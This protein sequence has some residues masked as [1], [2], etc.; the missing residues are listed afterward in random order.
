[1]NR[2]GISYQDIYTDM[3]VDEDSADHYVILTEHFIP[4]LTDGEV[5]TTLDNIHWGWFESNGYYD[6]SN[7]DAL[8]D[9]MISQ[10]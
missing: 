6:D 2:T 4:S 7:Y 3:W 5:E 8:V 10:W 1:M 9:D